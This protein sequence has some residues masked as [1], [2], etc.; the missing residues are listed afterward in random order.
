[1][2]APRLP[3]RALRV[4]L[5]AAAAAAMGVLVWASLLVAPDPDPAVWN[6][7]LTQRIF[8]YHVPSAWVAYLAFGTTFAASLYVLWKEDDPGAAPRVAAADR[9]AVA[10][11]EIGTLFSV[12][13]LVTGLVWSRVEFFNY[14]AFQDPKVISLLA[15][16]VA[17][18]AY[19]A[20]RRGV[21]DPAKRRRLGAVFG[22]AAFVGV[23]LTYYTSKVSVHPDFTREGS[24]ASGP[25]VAVLMVGL[26]AFTL[27]YAHLLL[28]RRDLLDLEER[29]DALSGAP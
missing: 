11:A 22:V 1:M 24:G 16:I 21:A 6:A 3:S 17:Y 2:P 27:L 13:A 9:W 15:L 26:V 25:M 4:A 7:P 18:L 14:D 29:L 23:P 28:F 20:L 5:L 12:V 19:F 10:S 8:Y